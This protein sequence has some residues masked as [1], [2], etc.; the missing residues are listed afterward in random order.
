MFRLHLRHRAGGGKHCTLL[1]C[2]MA[3]FLAASC[4][5]SADKVDDYVRKQMRLRHIPGLSLAVVKAGSIVKAKGYGLANVELRVP[6]SPE[7]VY[8]L[9]SLTKQFTATAI[10]LLVQDGKLSVD[11]NM[12]RYIANT[13]AGWADITLRHLLTHTSGLRDY[14]QEAEDAPNSSVKSYEETTPERIVQSIA[15]LPLDFAPGSKYAYSNTNYL[16]L[17][18]V[19]HQVSGQRYDQFLKERVFQPFGMAS[20]RLTSARAIIPN[21]AAGYTWRE[22]RWQ[23]SAALNPTLWDNG[24]GGLLSTVL[25]LAKWDAALYGDAILTSAMK[26]QMW[27]PVTLNDGTVGAYGFGWGIGNSKG[28]RLI[29]H[30]GG[31]PGTSTAIARY[32]DDE[33]TVIV[34]A[35]QD[36]SRVSEIANRIAG[37]YVAALAPPAYRT[38]RDNDPQITAGIKHLLSGFPQGRPIAD[39]LPSGIPVGVVGFPEPVKN[40]KSLYDQL[41]RLGAMRSMRLVERRIEGELRLYR[42]EVTYQDTQLLVGF[43]FDSIHKTVKMEF[44]LE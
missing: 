30:S 28:H 18:M 33:L 35:N 14:L 12:S 39:L 1:C 17:A 38:L 43:T 15:G 37:F 24:D 7:T 11:D 23:N 40:S 42:Y 34:L 16:L 10:M 41:R 8:Q 9:A 31:R 22:E 25:D 44:R 29:W 27:T 26:E 3:L 21:R 20:T 6:A 32:V 4:A 13:P 36:N 19:V 5:A 2:L